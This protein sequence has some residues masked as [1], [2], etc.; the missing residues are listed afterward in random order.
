VSGE[1]TAEPVGLEVV[2]GRLAS[3]LLS[4]TPGRTPE[5]VVGRILAVQAQD[6]RGA[7]LAVRARS[8]GL[9]V[10]DV[11]RA[12]SDDR[13]LVIIWLNRGTLHLVR[14]DDYAWLHGLLAGRY[15]TWTKR[16]LRELYVSPDQAE[17]SVELIVRSIEREGPLTRAEVTERLAR[18]GLPSRGQAVPHQLGLASFRGLIVRGPV[19][20]RE[21]CYVLVRDW[22]GDPPPFDHER[23]LAELAR[24]YLAG[25]APASAEDLAYWTGLPIGQVKAGLRA[26]GSELRE[27]P[28]GLVELARRE[29]DPAEQPPVPVGRLLGPFD[30]L[31]HGWPSREAILGPHK[32]LV[33]MNGIFRATLLVRGRAAGTWTMPNGKVALEPFETLGPEE[34]DALGLDARDVERFFDRAGSPGAA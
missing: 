14:S 6:L 34:S 15:L 12:F 1:A 10:G 19:R 9:T 30:P 7:R 21:Q 33:T 18:A 4:G 20:A 2:R 17:R 32:S 26:I 11:D 3:Q 8:T 25:H 22:L 27:R 24:R 5:D 16:R 29:G 13:S 23:A 31:L 28:D